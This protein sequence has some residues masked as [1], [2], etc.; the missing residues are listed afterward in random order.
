MD[1]FMERRAVFVYE[2]ARIAAVAA[3]APVVPA[4]WEER[5][6]DFREQF[7]RVV[8]RRTRTLCLFCCAR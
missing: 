5:E 3:S 7:I 4:V 1:E 8:E 6:E 2:G